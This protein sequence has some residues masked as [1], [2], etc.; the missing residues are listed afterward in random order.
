M[1]KLIFLDIDGVLNCSSTKE[2]IERYV[3]VDSNKLNL[4]KQIVDATNAKIVLVSTWKE[5]WYK[6]PQR[7]SKQDFLAQYLDER[8]S[9]FDLKISDKTD[10][11]Y[12]VNRGEGIKEYIANLEHLGIEVSNYIIIDDEIFDYLSTKMTKKL[13]RTSFK[14]GLQEKHVKKAIAMLS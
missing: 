12:M 13:V 7:K 14:N 6:E 5:Y 9:E 3:G 8:M 11:Y 1:L 10:N 2:R 4:L